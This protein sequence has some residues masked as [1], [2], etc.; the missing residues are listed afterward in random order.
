MATLVTTRVNDAEKEL[1]ALVTNL[2]NEEVKKFLPDAQEVA[3]IS[4]RDYFQ[5]H[6]QRQTR[7]IVEQVV[8]RVQSFLNEEIPAQM[9]SVHDTLVTMNKAVLDQQELVSGHEI[10][11]AA[12]LR[13]VEELQALIALAL[14]D[15]SGNSSPIGTKAKHS[16]KLK[17]QAKREAYAK[18]LAQIMAGDSD[19]PDG[20]SSSD[21]SDN[22]KTTRG[23][24]DGDDEEGPP[25]KVEKPTPH[26]SP[27]QLAAATR[28]LSYPGLEE[29]RPMNARFT[30]VLSYKLYRLRNTNWNGKKT[31]KRFNTMFKTVSNRME[32]LKF[33][34]SDPMA[35]LTFL[36]A[37]RTEA[38]EVDMSEATAVSMIQKFLGEPCRSM[39]QSNLRHTGVIDLYD[40]GARTD[41]ISHWAEAV[42]WLLRTYARD[43][44]IQ[45]EVIELRAIKQR[46]G[47]T[48]LAYHTRLVKKYSRLGSVYSQEDQILQY[49]EGLKP[50]VMN[51]VLRHRTAEPA[52]YNTLS[53]VADL[54]DSFGRSERARHQGRKVRLP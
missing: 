52:R 18:K 54:A 12:T 26:P 29:L 41:T 20:S 19:P 49:I 50:T 6:G 10:Q 37:F 39:F 35:I 2:M 32:P 28:D 15:E 22:T 42:N 7:L 24:R 40:N 16:R 25:L 9:K 8:N 38:D 17:R 11:I 36:S 34:C 13:K 1:R 14:R 47:E 21:D 33:T 23:N 48:E 3:R 53:L 51:D 27:A 46:E 44:Y 30:K 5:E 45:Q 31:E 4:A 43:T